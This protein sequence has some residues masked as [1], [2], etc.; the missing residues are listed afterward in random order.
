[1][2]AAR[3][4]KSFDS[5][6]A[7]DSVLYFQRGRQGVPIGRKVAIMCMCKRKGLTNPPNIP[8]RLCTPREAPRGRL[9]KK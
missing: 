5:D 1:M 9:F 7:I 6:S 3:E 4:E 8:Q 2:Q